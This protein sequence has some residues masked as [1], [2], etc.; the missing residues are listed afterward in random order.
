MNEA[1]ISYQTPD[2]QAPDFQIIYPY[3]HRVRP[4]DLIDFTMPL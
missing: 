1:L 3:S 4:N 2:V